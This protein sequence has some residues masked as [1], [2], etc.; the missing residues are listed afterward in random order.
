VSVLTARFAILKPFDCWH[1]AAA[2]PLLAH[3]AFPFHSKWGWIARMR[4]LRRNALSVA[5]VVAACAIAWPAS[6]QDV[7]HL[8]VKFKDVPAKMSLPTAERLAHLSADHAVVL[9]P[10]REMA[11]GAHV[12]ALDA[13]L[14]RADAERVAAQLRTSA[15]V[16]YVEPDLPRHAAKIA[17]DEFRFAQGYLDDVPAGISASRAWDVTTGSS[18]TVVAVVDTGIRP[19]IDM[20]GRILPG[21]DMVTSLTVSND[22]DGR[23]PDASDPGDWITA[24]ERTGDWSDCTIRNSSWHGTE[25]A[26]VIA[27]DSNNGLWTSGINW[28]AKILPV[29]VLGKCGGFD[30]DVI[31]GV[32]WAAGLAVPGVPANPNPAHVINLSLGGD[33]ACHQAYLDVINATY[34]HGVTRA[35]VAA[36]GNDAEDVAGHSPASC[37]GIIAVAS[38]TSIGTLASYSNFGTG[39]S[40]S[41]PGGQYQPRAG[42][43]GIIALSNFGTTVPTT[44]TYAVSGGTSLAAPMVSGVVSLMLAVAPNLTSS[45]VHAILTATAKPFPAGSDCT[46]D[47]CGSGIVDAAAAVTAAAAI[48][49]TAP[50]TV[51][52]IEFYNASLDHYFITWVSQE[53]AKLDAGMTPT[54]WTRTG[55]GFKTQTSAHSGTSPVCRFYIPPA[56]GDSHFFGRGT[57]ECNATALKNPDFVLE[58]PA[59]MQMTLPNAGVCPAGTTPVYRVFSNRIDANHRYMTDRTVRAQMVALGWLAEGDGPDLVVMCAPGP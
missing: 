36:A 39:I 35:I 55:Y 33:G 1:R 45:Q 23:D 38:T 21:Y 9:R 6:A 16:E 34:A 51:D 37:P 52:V 47:R 25:V 30:S 32:A 59:F 42:T 11:L 44:D 8:I 22:G 43:S 54:R 24:D 31:D 48:V 17:N 4:S 26:G 18:A 5:A 20:T 19:H 50:E 40:L 53:I 2:F 7:T 13:P 57:V 29:R 3:T 49:S 10:L 15:D 28:A 58:D 14:S 27:A 46:P 12:V 56:K 41:A